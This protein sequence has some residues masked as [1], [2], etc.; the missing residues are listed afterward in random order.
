MGRKG[1]EVRKPTEEESAS[2]G[3]K[4]WLPRTG[5]RRGCEVSTSPW[6]YEDREVCYVLA[7]RVR[8]EGRDED[9][10]IE[11]A[12][13]GPGDLVTFPRGLKVTWQVIEPVR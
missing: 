1:I 12:E 7:G 11:P 9:S 6:E 4:S 2:L 13:F 10:D 3:A 5:W 8:V